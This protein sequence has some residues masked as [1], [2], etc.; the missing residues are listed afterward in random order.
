MKATFAA[1]IVLGLR[2]EIRYLQ[3]PP[4]I[5]GSRLSCSSAFSLFKILGRFSLAQTHKNKS[6]SPVYPSGEVILWYSCRWVEHSSM[7]AAWSI[8]VDRSECTVGPRGLRPSHLHKC[9]MC[10]RA[11]AP[12]GCS[13]CLHLARGRGPVLCP[14]ECAPVWAPRPYWWRACVR[15]PDVSGCNTPLRRSTTMALAG[16]AIGPSSACQSHPTRRTL[17]KICCKRKHMYTVY[18]H[19]YKYVLASFLY[20]LPLFPLFSIASLHAFSFFLISFILS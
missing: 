13:G 6:L 11:V 12:F 9:A 15:Q 19:V 1:A 4:A 7:R 5:L 20:L 16:H 2:F 3:R 14:S 8:P 18:V 17:L 10:P